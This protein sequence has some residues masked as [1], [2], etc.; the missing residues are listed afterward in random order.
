MNANFEKVS[1]KVRIKKELIIL[2]EEQIEQG[3]ISK[4][5][6]SEFDLY[7]LNYTNKCQMD[8]LWDDATK[9]CRGLI[10]DSNYNLVSRSY[11]KFFTIDQIEDSECDVLPPED[12]N[13]EIAHKKDG[14]LGVSYFVEDKMY[15]SSRGSF[16]S[17]MAKRANKILNSKYS[18]CN[19]DS[20]YSY[21]FEIIYPNAI[22]TLSYKYEALVL[23]GI[24]DNR[25]GEEVWLSD[26]SDHVKDL[27]RNG[28][29]V[30]WAV[31]SGENFTGIEE[32]YKR[33]KYDEDEGY[34]IS[35]PNGY[36]V[37]VK[38]DEYKKMSRAKSSLSVPGTK[39]FVKNVASGMIEQAFVTNPFLE[40]EERR[41]AVDEV[42]DMYEN[43]Y[44]QSLELMNDIYKLESVTD[45]A[46]FHQYVSSN[47]DKSFASI[48]VN[49]YLMREDRIEKSIWKLVNICYI[50]IK[51]D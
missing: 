35:F 16:G 41:K 1:G 38:F 9:F 26:I 45:I 32:F 25:T 19:F 23:H 48:L 34:V 10:V 2:I 43:I 14:F 31:E 18:K 49:M 46:T 8:W 42:Y 33:F 30:E 39:S 4:T 15:I 24:F 51:L 21:V 29:P 44:M 3:Y 20:N 28:L 36:K 50:I 47:V 11:Y 13:Y 12:M 7:N 6:H 5:K 37:K 17:D 22:L 40:S 27:E